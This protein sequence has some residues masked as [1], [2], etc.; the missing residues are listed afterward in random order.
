MFNYVR[1]QVE[2]S[3]T[4]SF[5]VEVAPWEVPVVMAVNGDDRCSV[6]GEI[7]V[8]RE[9]PDAQSEYDRLALKYKMDTE[10][11]QAFVAMVYGVGAQGVRALKQAIK[12]VETYKQGAEPKAAPAG[13]VGEE[14]DPTAELFETTPKVAEGARAIS[15]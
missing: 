11:G 14:F 4:L 9:L 7:P 3:E 10:S 5:P 2:R 8:R 1:V 15:E 6:V 13:D 12:E